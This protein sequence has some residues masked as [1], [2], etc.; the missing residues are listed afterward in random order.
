MA[1]RCDCKDQVWMCTAGN[2][3]QLEY[4]GDH[5]EHSQAN[6]KSKKLRHTG[7]QIFAINNAVFVGANGCRLVHGY[8]ADLSDFSVISGSLIH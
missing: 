8:Q 1:K 4:S 2:Y 5:D 7:K 6:D 3:K